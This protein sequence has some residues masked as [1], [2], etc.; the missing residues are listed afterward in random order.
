MRVW[1]SSIRKLTP[2]E[3]VSGWDDP[4]LPT[5]VGFR[6]RGYSPQGINNF[7]T[8]IGVTTNNSITPIEKLEHFV[9]L[10]LNASSRRIFA[11]MDPIKVT[12]RNGN[13]MSDGRAK[14][15]A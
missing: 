7:C 9:R 6:R 13:G 5:I 15:T 4:R 2:K 12:I 14:L 11:V 1:F 8:D 10:D 3:Y